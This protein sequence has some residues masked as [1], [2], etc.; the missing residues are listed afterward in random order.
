VTRGIYSRINPQRFRLN[1]PV[2]PEA[3]RSLEFQS[4]SHQINDILITH[5]RLGQRVSDTSRLFHAALDPPDRFRFHT[6]SAID[7]AS[8]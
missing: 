6:V 4:Q 1:E 7:L 2:Q 5:N 8:L 3:C